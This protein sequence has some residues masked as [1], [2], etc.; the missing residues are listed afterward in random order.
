ME[1]EDHYW[2]HQV[3]RSLVLA[4]LNIRLGESA[5]ILDVG[6]GTGGMLNQISKE[7]P[8][9][10]C[11][12]IDA[13][14]SAVGYCHGRGLGNVTVADASDLPFPAG[15]FDAVL[16]LDVLYHE[17]VA[18]EL[19]LAEMQRV[20]KSGGCFTLNLPAFDLLRGAH[21]KA[22]CGARR[23]KVGQVLK[24]LSSVKMRVKLIHYWNAWLFCPLLLWR[25]C[26]RIKRMQSSD[27]QTL[28]LWLNG[29]LEHCGRVD[30]KMSRLLRLP[31][32][33]SLF[34]VAGKR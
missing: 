22:V 12:G 17:A 29:I 18:E 28:P 4:E 20:V 3:L 15:T 5:K 8:L 13:S 33:S 23:Y 34:V 21:D 14:A 31:F 9:W 6:C 25:H 26:S 27:M 24:M 7:R 10:G 1:V 11:V 2:W 30:T 32:G 16:C 19:A